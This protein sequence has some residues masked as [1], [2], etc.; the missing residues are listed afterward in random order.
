[1]RAT[2]TAEFCEQLR[3]DSECA[4]IFRRLVCTAIETKFKYGSVLTELHEVG[5][6]LALIPEFLP[7]VGR[8]HHDVYHVYTVDVHSVAAVDKMRAIFRGDLADSQQLATRLVEDISRPE[9]LFFA[10]LLHDV[11]KDAGGKNHAERGADLA[12]AILTRLR[13]PKESIHGVQHLIRKHL[14]MYLIA[15]RRDVDDPRTLERFC[16]D[17]EGTEG[18]R[19]LY[20]LTVADVSTTSPTALTPWKQRMLDE[21]Y[22]ATELWLTAGET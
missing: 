14:K 19:E 15:T 8:V 9:V 1:M 18:L 21:L 12:D 7:V 2:S 20:L 3:A 17:L 5:L 16:A 11:G 22:Y 4:P 13:F 6:L 10:T